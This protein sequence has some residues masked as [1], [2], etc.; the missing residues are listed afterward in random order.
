[1]MFYQNMPLYLAL[2]NLLKIE[3]LYVHHLSREYRYNLGQKLIDLLLEML[4]D[5]VR[6]QTQ[7][8]TVKE[9]IVLVQVLD[10]KCAMLNLRHR[11]LTE[12]GQLS[13]KQSAFLGQQV[14]PIGKMI[15]SWLK[16]LELRNQAPEFKSEFKPKFKTATKLIKTGQ[17]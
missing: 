7:A 14:L 1:M 5:F 11:F 2:F 6:I 8:K 10:S 4:D 3:H 17:G 9:K 13:L 15:G 16:Q 12:V